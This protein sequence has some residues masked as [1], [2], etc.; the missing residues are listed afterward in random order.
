[1]GVSCFQDFYNGS[2]GFN[3]VRDIRKAGEIEALKH[4]FAVKMNLGDPDFVD[5]SKVLSDMLSPKFA[6]EL[7]KTIY[8]NMTF[9]PGHYGGRWNQINDHG[10]SHLS[11]VDRE[12]N[13]ISMTTTDFHHQRQLTL[14]AQE[15]A[16]I[17]HVTY[18]SPEE[19]SCTITTMCLLYMIV[20]DK[21]LKGVVGASGGS[22]IIAGT[23]ELL[24]NK[25]YYE[26]WTTVIGDHF[27]VPA[28]IREDLQKKGHVLEALAGGTICQFIALGDAETSKENGD[29]GKLVA[30]SDPRKG[31]IPSGY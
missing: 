24:P 6:K 17:I 12:R 25:V 13:A 11:I 18:N 23:A 22:M 8:D 9:D 27:E 5:V 20:Q 10:T 3:L 28:H 7:K 16:V 31:G 1:M 4:A 2:V 14:S 29:V 26:N 19:N 15:K 30:V 21:Q